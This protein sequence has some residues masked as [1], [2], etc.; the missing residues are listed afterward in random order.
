MFKWL[1]LIQLVFPDKH[2]QTNMFP[3]ESKEECLT[4]ASR[5]LD[6]DPGDFKAVSVGVACIKEKLPEDPA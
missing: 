1:L 3:V 4:M 6:K 2:P 5:I